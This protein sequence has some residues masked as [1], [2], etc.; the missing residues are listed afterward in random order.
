MTSEGTTRRSVRISDEIWLAALTKA[1]RRRETISD[2]LR[3]ALVTY[4]NEDTTDDNPT[5][6]QGRA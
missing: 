5:S 4:I 1:R 3:R 2:V 6:H